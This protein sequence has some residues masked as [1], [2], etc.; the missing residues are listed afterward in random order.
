MFETILLNEVR[1]YN[2]YANKHRDLFYYGVRGAGDIDLIVQLA[3]KTKSAPD[4]IVAIEFKLGSSWRSEWAKSLD[5]LNKEHNHTVVTKSILVY[6]GT[7]LEQHGNVQVVPFRDF[8][9]QL[10]RGEIF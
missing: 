9:D 8:L 1:A 6:T 3:K 4:K 2:E 10:H 5:L 7:R